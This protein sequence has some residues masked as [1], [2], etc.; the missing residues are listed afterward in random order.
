[1]TQ[2]GQHVKGIIEQYPATF[3]ITPNWK[4][5]LFGLLFLPLFVSL[6]FWQLD[7]S[8]EKQKILE[9]FYQQQALTPVSFLEYDASQPFQA[10]SLQGHFDSKQFWLLENQVYQGRNG[11]RVIAPFYLQPSVAPNESSAVLVDLDWVAAPPTRDYLPEVSFQTARQTLVGFIIQPADNPLLSYS[12]ERVA[13][14]WPRRIVEVDIS[15]M[16]EEKGVVLFDGLLKL[17]RL[18]PPLNTTPEKHQGYAVQWF[19]MAVALLLALLI[20][21]TNLVAVIKG[22]RQ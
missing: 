4:L 3:S 8:E 9:A 18:Q 5:S 13:G 19:A 14:E 7:R 17:D 12:S 20:A 21:N 2:E 22:I 6:G 15:A 1:M 11:Y 10:V 16:A